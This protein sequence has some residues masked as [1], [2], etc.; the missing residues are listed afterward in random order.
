M[1]FQN[2]ICITEI[3]F[4]EIVGSVSSYIKK[5]M[6]L[7]RKPLEPGL[8]VAK[9]LRFLATLISFK[10]LGFAFHVVPN[11]IF[12]VVPKMCK[13][14]VA[15]FRDELLQMVDSVQSWEKIANGF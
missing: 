8:R 11:T 3:M 1:L 14:I 15:V 9:T 4:N 2:F 7:R 6:T 10:S 5:R 13:T 12:L